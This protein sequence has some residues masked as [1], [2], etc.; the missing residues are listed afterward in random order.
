ME[1]SI[2]GLQKSLHIV[3]CL[4]KSQQPLWNNQN[5]SCPSCPIDTTTLRITAIDNRNED[6]SLVTAITNCHS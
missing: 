5:Y 4:L 6:M 1:I 2:L 3:E